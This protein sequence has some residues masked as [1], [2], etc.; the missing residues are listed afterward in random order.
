MNN[1]KQESTIKKLYNKSPN[2]KNRRER[3]MIVYNRHK[4]DEAYINR[5]NHYKSPYNKHTSID[6][7]NTLHTHI[8]RSSSNGNRKQAYD[9]SDDDVTI[10]K[11]A[12]IDL[13]RHIS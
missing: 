6:H 9:L 10:F 8:Q 7:Y 1:T 11:Y 3:L 12:K 4:M 13:R 2:S 5:V